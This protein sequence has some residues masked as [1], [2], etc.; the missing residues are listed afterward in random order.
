MQQ[1]AWLVTN[2][3][4]HSNTPGPALY[5]NLHPAACYRGLRAVRN[6]PETRSEGRQARVF[7][8]GGPGEPT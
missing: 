7:V 4:A 6:F 8:S 3:T 2:S 1:R 5:H